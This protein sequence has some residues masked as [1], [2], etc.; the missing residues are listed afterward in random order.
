MTSKIV[1]VGGGLSGLCA[2]LFL[3]N[4]GLGDK[5]IVIEKEDECGG[6]LS[7]FNYGEM[8]HFD[9]GIHHF[10]ETGVKE[11]DQQLFDIFNF[12]DWRELSG[13]ERTLAGNYF[14]GRLNTK[15]QYCCLKDLENGKDLLADFIENHEKNNVEKVCVKSLQQALQSK[16]GSLITKTIIN[17]ILER[18]F[19]A[20]HSELDNLS[21]SLCPFDRVGLFEE[22]KCIELL[23]SQMSSSIA[24][25]DQRNLP[26]HKHSTLKSYYP[27]RYGLSYVIEGLTKKLQAK[28][29]SIMMNRWVKELD[30]SDKCVNRVVLDNGDKIDV[31]TLIWSI[32]LPS[33]SKA[34]QIKSSDI[35]FDKPVKTVLVNMLVSKVNS[36]DDLHSFFCYDEL[37]LNI[38]RVT[39]YAN[40]CEDAKRNELYPL[41]VEVFF[42][43]LGSL[44]KTEIGELAIAALIKMGVL[45]RTDDVKFIATEF[46]ATG[47][48]KPTNK[49]VSGMNELR[50]R[51]E[52]KQIEN[53]LLCGIL[54]QEN[55][56]FMTDVIK[57]TYDLCKGVNRSKSSMS[58]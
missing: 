18:K 22:A 44:D 39:N 24:F 57:R 41:S 42:D 11:I 50:S 9:K 35:P 29:V 36:M 12:A 37:D 13:T 49:N 27:I 55:L 40:Y 46:L 26:V 28:G 8:G 47:F 15:T 4:R 7:S 16:F 53:L 48:P 56:F 2:G 10:S 19:Y 45:E 30:T 32:G 17:P 33:L 5:V 43:E 51:I 1:I 34:L 54:S 3:A 58:Y 38:Y 14:N 52:S 21:I 25:Q 31:E 23:N 20:P 6:L